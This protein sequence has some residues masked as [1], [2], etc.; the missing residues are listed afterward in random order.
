MAAET[1]P[2]EV[3]CRAL[4]KTFPGGVEAV[5]PLDTAFA[6]GRTTALVGPSGCGKS[7][8]LRM[9]AG[10]EPP[11]GGEV[12]IGGAPPAA[13]RRRAGLAIAFQD[14]SLLPWRTVRGNIRLARRLARQ[15]ADPA[16]VDQL[17]RL[18]GLDGFAET[19]PAALSGGMRQRAA[20]ARCLV[21]GPELLLLD[22]PFGAVDELTRRQLAQDLPRIWQAR[23][24]TTLLVTHSVTEA[25]L[26]SDRVLVFSPRPARL[27]ADIEIDLPHPRTDAMT[28][29]AGF[30]DPAHRVSEAL[31][32]GIAGGRG[33]LAAQ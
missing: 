5:R 17:I 29:G 22:E 25:I 27:V 7:T 10:L 19:R 14:A 26:L 31:S 15:P 28:T 20:I 21:T 3:R 11:T 1:G 6:A 18:V 33:T 2:P 32:R 30:L 4:A 24:T 12:T 16:A 9:I 23:G 13:I 8:I